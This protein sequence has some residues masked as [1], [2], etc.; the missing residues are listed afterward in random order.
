MDIRFKQREKTSRIANETEN[1]QEKLIMH[2]YEIAQERITLTITADSVRIGKDNLIVF[3]K[4][5]EIIAI[6]NGKDTKCIMRIE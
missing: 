2:R 5:E 4:G 1:K 3:E 6:V